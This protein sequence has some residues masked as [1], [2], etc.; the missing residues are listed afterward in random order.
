MNRQVLPREQQVLEFRPYGNAG[1]HDVAAVFLQAVGSPVGDSGVMPVGEG[2]GRVRLFDRRPQTKSVRCSATA[3]FRA[4]YAS[5]R[6]PG[7][8]PLHADQMSVAIGAISVTTS[9]HA[10]SAHGGC[11]LNN[12]IFGRM[13]SVSKSVSQTSPP[14]A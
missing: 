12:T 5:G 10:G 6:R 8:D 11:A 1:R 3:V 2:R 14:S 7:A 9:L 4:V 13:A